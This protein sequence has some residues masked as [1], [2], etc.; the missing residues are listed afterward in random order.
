[1]ASAIGMVEYMTVSI[2]IDATD[3][4]LKTSEVELVEA[5]VVCP[6]KYIS[7]IRGDLS[8]VRA[9]VDAAKAT[10][11]SNIKKSRS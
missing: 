1:M 4:M 8:A 6:G 10:T 9:A 11:K 2:G 7:I 5:Q 3:T